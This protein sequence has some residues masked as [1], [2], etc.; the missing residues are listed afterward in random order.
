MTQN[1]TKLAACFLILLFAAQAFCSLFHKSSTV[2]EVLYIPAGYVYLKSGSYM[3]NPETPPLP[4]ILCGIP[5]LFLNNIKYD[6]KEP[7]ADFNNRYHW[8]FRFLFFQN[9]ALAGK[10]MFYSRIPTI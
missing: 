9:T 7:V 3:L 1:V 10:I 2:D 5:L 8:S 6:P 4:R